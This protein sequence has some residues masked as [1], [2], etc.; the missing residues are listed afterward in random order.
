MSLIINADGEELYANILLAAAGLTEC[1]IGTWVKRDSASSAYQSYVFA[2]RAIDDSYGSV[3]IAH[4]GAG[5]DCFVVPSGSQRR[6]VNASDA[7][8]TA[9]QLLI[10]T[11]K[12]DVATKVHAGIT[13]GSLVTTIGITDANSFNSDLDWIRI[14]GG[15]D[16]NAAWWPRCRL[17]HSFFYDIALS[18]AECGELFNGGTAGAGKNPQAVRGANLKFYAPLTSGA[19]VTVGGVSLSAA[20]TLTYDGADNPNVDA[21]GADTTAPTLTSASVTSVGTTTATGNVTTNEGN[22]TLYSIV[23]TSSTAPSATQIQAGQ[24]HTGAAAVWSGNQAVSSTGAKTFSITGLTASTSYYAYFQHKDAANNNSSVV[25]SAQFTTGSADTTNP[26]MTGS[27]TIS[28]KTTTSYTATWS[29]G[30]DNVSVTGYEY[31]L[32]AG[33]WVDLGNVLTVNISARTP[34]ATDTFEVRAYDA[35]GNRATAL[36]QSVTLYIG[37]ITL[38]DI[39]QWETGALKP[40][41][42]GVTVDISNISTGALVVRKTG[43]VTTAGSDMEIKDALIADATLYRVVTEFA[44]GSL[45][46]R[47]I[48]SSLT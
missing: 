21:Y 46:I 4:N 12:K 36:S 47:N 39:T 14:G 35:A 19:T 25:T 16:N 9:W 27:V 18:D 42:T 24:N 40:S 2:G 37:T 20:G 34:G 28:A 17:G 23:S 5:S 33:S 32:N 48:T 45:G 10:Q 8:S 22:G 26:T 6:T 31:R 13:G 38:T 7:N 3:W 1:T 15:A 11:F 41:Q 43:Q 29:A 30:S 44:D